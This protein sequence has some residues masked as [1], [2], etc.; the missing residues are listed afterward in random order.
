MTRR[1]F[2]FSPGRRDVDSPLQLS[3]PIPLKITNA[4]ANANANPKF[5]NH[6]SGI[7][8]VGVG[9]VGVGVGVDT[10][11]DT[12]NGVEIELQDLDAQLQLKSKSR[13]QSQSQTPEQSAEQELSHLQLPVM[14]SLPLSLQPQSIAS[15]HSSEIA[16]APP[17][18]SFSL[19]R[20]LSPLRLRKK[21]SSSPLTI[22]RNEKD[23]SLSP[24]KTR[25]HSNHN[26]NHNHNPPSSPSRR[27]PSPQFKKFQSNS[28][29]RDPSLSPVKVRKPP[30]PSRRSPSPPQK[31]RKSPL[32]YQ[33]LRNDTVPSEDHPPVSATGNAA[34]TA[35]ENAAATAT[36]NATGN[37][38]SAI[39]DD[40][41]NSN[42]VNP[43]VHIAE[44]MN[45]NQE[46]RLQA[47][48]DLFGVAAETIKDVDTK[49]YQISSMGK[50]V[51]WL[52]K[53]V[54]EMESDKDR[55]NR[56]GVETKKEVRR[57][58]GLLSSSMSMSMDS[59]GTGS[60]ASIPMPVHD[61]NEVDMLKTELDS[62]DVI[63]DA[64]Q[65][66]LE[67]W[68]RQE[69]KIAASASEQYS[70]AEVDQIRQVHK[71]ELAKVKAQ[72]DAK[73]KEQS[74]LISQQKT[75]IR[76][77]REDVQEKNRAIDDL[78]ADVS[79]LRDSARGGH[80][81]IDTNSDSIYAELEQT[82]ET[83]KKLK[84]EYILEIKK[85]LQEKELAAT[86]NGPSEQIP[87]KPEENPKVPK[88]TESSDSIVPQL[89]T[90]N[91]SI[92][93]NIP[94]GT[95][96]HRVAMAASRAMKNTTM[97]QPYLQLKPKEHSPQSLSASR[98]KEGNNPKGVSVEEHEKV[99]SQLRE[100]GIVIEN[101]KSD[102]KA[103]ITKLVAEKM[104]CEHHLEE[105]MDT[106]KVE[107]GKLSGERIEL[108]HRLKLM[109]ESHGSEVNRLLE[110]KAESESRLED[111]QNSEEADISTLLSEKMSLEKHISTLERQLQKSD[112]N[113]VTKEDEN[114]FSELEE[115]YRAE[116]EGLLAEKKEC[117]HRLKELEGAHEDKVSKFLAERS[118]N[119]RHL[120]E[121]DGAYQKELTKMTAEKKSCEQHIS[122]LEQ[123]VKDMN[124]EIMNAKAQ[125][126]ASQVGE[127]TCESDEG[128]TSEEMEFTRKQNRDLRTKV[129]TLEEELDT[130]G[131]LL[132]ETIMSIK[133][134][135]DEIDAL[136]HNPN[137]N[138][139][140]L[141]RFGG[142]G[143]APKPSITNS[144]Q[145]TDEEVQQLTRICK[146]HQLTIT[147][148]RVQGKEMFRQ[149]T[150]AK[151]LVQRYEAEA[152]ENEEKVAVLEK[153]FIEL[154]QAMEE[155]PPNLEDNDE[156]LRSSIIKIDAAYVTSLKDRSI[157]LQNQIKALRERNE[158][159]HEQA[160]I[161][162]VLKAQVDDLTLALE[163]KTMEMQ[164]LA[165]AYESN[166]SSG[167][168]SGGL[169][170]AELEHGYLD[171]DLTAEDLRQI[172]AKKDRMIK[173]LQNKMAHLE[174]T[175]RTAGPRGAVINLRK[176]TLL[177]EM[178]DA[179]VR[180]LNILINRMD[181]TRETEEELEEEFMSPSKS[182]MISMS[183]KLSLL[184]DYQKISL[185]L[186]ESRLSN[187]I[188]SL[189]SGGK[190]VEMDK[191]VEARFERTLESLTK[192]EK[193]VEYQLE[194]FS[195]ELQHHNIKLSAK[196]GV[197]KTLLAKDN[198]RQSTIE[199]FAD[200]LKV[201]KGLD[202]FQ[203]I[204][205][206]VMARFKECAKLE[207]E[208][209]DKDMIIKRLNSV[210][211]EYRYDHQ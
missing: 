93:V 17:S 203:N 124:E 152:K 57:L 187:E 65:R 167:K 72:K 37:N 120:E 73:I 20:K 204:N 211:E 27:S 52:M 112:T 125:S 178:Q 153:H 58:R 107:H 194:Q 108:E 95:V 101:L 91:R 70:K 198:E 9:N 18:S 210:I 64:L 184:H 8:I 90:V 207:K 82:K 137:G 7:G 22:K 23:A 128:A 94:V 126:Q 4:N 135:D 32:H 181:D 117:E 176:V 133:E 47:Y 169:K 86:Q 165:D 54:S 21:L 129:V 12:G 38:K 87:S 205:A 26:Q 13:L 170:G 174:Q 55:L 14:N 10:S 84:I 63:I 113:K 185:H 75:L 80:T 200:D 45:L 61:P 121:I 188:E 177:Q 130:V 196:N 183:D 163:A 146:L 92:E 44:Y 197:I 24:V 62:K 39:L 136:R 28:K 162:N 168:F 186:L 40:D 66:S 206:G 154:N 179:I 199:S 147:R 11:M 88:E 190:P 155:N 182:F 43:L 131:G 208:L 201:Y 5:R 16:L 164:K 68:K 118:E 159:F 109:E 172:V 175:L 2:G 102:H 67:E 127:T 110:E 56:K 189:R 3:N 69:K 74:F 122:T 34:A 19:V 202:Q 99:L 180:R 77:T 195:L 6:V 85:L 139:G 36:G 166:R 119:K 89:N 42:D 15:D 30:S 150:E 116:I 25:N 123:E 151:T 48:C 148:Q 81:N 144:S 111:I 1:V 193:D 191:E 31:G 149:L 100:Y 53:R 156:N 71:A 96:R 141:G 132:E 98:R 59:T 142:G 33:S 103:E 157:E 140:V 143:P 29:S 160:N 115:G 35:T 161:D 50:Q 78:R 104:E 105:I 51:D 41:S 114:K 60:T 76:E 171:D 173:Q 79:E 83:M 138:K 145:Y 106:H 134:K 97:S 192:S 158:V 209:E 49:R 46:E